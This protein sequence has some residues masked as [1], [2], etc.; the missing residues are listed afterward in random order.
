MTASTETDLL[1]GPSFTTPHRVDD[2]A[3]DAGALAAVNGDFFNNTVDAGHGDA[4][5]RPDADDTDVQ[6]VGPRQRGL[7]PVGQ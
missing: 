7:D 3:S 6:R 5:A 1:A 2:L 4:D